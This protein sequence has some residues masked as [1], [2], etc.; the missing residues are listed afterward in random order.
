MAKDVS[1]SVN[2]ALRLLDCFTQS[3]ELGITEL[4]ADLDLGKTAVARLV[5]SLEQYGYIRQNAQTKKYRLGVKLMLLGTL[6][7]ERN[8]IVPLAKPY[9]MA[10]SEEFQA[11]AHLA[12][13]DS[14]AALIISKVSRGPVVYMSSRVG[15]TI[16]A[17]AS[18][19]GKCL[20]AFSGGGVMKEFLSA[21]SLDGYTEH[22]ITDQTE[23][24]MELK[25]V[26][27]Q[28][29]AFD[30]EESNLGLFCIAMPVLDACG[31]A[32]AAISVSGQTQTMTARKEEIIRRLGKC[33]ESISRSM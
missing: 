9:L 11:T 2:N 13:L 12:V 31:N 6:A 5:G 7:S 1:Q 8:E 18:A 20:L 16:P 17:H 19:T 15:T 22:T 24:L 29:Y 23:L 26:Y 30:N 3:E 33:V 28:G 21:K 25:K 4:A 27:A 32:L 14:N 10:L